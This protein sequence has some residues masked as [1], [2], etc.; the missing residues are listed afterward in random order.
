MDGHKL[1]RLE[2]GGQRRRHGTRN[3]QGSTESKVG[4][5]EMHGP[6][7]GKEQGVGRSKAKARAR[8]LPLFVGSREQMVGRNNGNGPA[9]QSP[10][11]RVG[12]PNSMA[13]WEPRRIKGSRTGN[14]RRLGGTKEES[15]GKRTKIAKR[16]KG[17]R[18]SSIVGGN[19]SSNGGRA[20]SRDRVLKLDTLVT[21]VVATDKKGVKIS[22]RHWGRGFG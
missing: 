7:T 1:S 11:R 4:P 15:T 22:H 14:R 8:L 3:V 21:L 17:N 5:K 19:Q 18:N 9:V 20:M 2:V 10:T 12:N 16:I 13:G 6:V